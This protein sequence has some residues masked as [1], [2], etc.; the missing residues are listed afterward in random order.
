MV[1]PPLGSKLEENCEFTQLSNELFRGEFGDDID[2]KMMFGEGL[3]PVFG[4]RMPY[5]AM[6]NQHACQRKP[7]TMK[8]CRGWV[9]TADKI[10]QRGFTMGPFTLPCGCHACASHGSR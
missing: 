5:E 1:G 9:E 2:W 10:L 3:D 6:N 8:E 7:H 4:Y